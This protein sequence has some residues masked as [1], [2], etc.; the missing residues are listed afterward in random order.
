MTQYIYMM[1]GAAR[2]A[3]A[4]PLLSRTFS[5]TLVWYLVM[6]HVLK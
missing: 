1:V 5:P 2:Q 4:N 3:Q 6:L